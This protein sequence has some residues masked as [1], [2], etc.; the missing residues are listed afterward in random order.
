MTHRPLLVLIAAS[1][2]LLAGCAAP[3]TKP[4]VIAPTPAQMERGFRIVLDQSI[5]GDPKLWDRC[6]QLGSFAA[7]AMIQLQHRAPGTAD[8]YSVESSPLGK[9]TLAA[10]QAKYGPA[11]HVGRDAGFEVHYYGLFGFGTKDGG[12][13]FGYLTAP[14]AA[15]LNGIEKVAR[16]GL[17]R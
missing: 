2:A 17:Q 6:T 15:Y 10:I 7:R 3:Q 14:M 16:K 9:G 4:H 12:A 1:A 5:W 13:S 8:F 11:D